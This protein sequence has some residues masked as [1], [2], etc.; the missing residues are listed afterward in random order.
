MDT[1]SD[2]Q[3]IEAF[4]EIKGAGNKLKAYADFNGGVLFGVT[5]AGELI[6]IND[7]SGQVLARADFG[8]LAGDFEFQGLALGP[9]NVEGGTYANTLFAITRNGLLHAIDPA[10]L[11]GNL[12]IA[13]T[14]QNSLVNV[15]DTNNDGVADSTSVDTGR[16]NV[17]DDE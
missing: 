9:Q 3:L 11:V 5:D 16:T 7:T 12:S 1:P 13:A 8:M 10:Q 6:L 4:D 2:S 15:F 14:L 17:E